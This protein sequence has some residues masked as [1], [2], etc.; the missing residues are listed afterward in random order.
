[1]TNDNVEIHGWKA[2]VRDSDNSILGIVTDKYKV[3]QNTEA[4]E[5]TDNL[6]GNGVRYETAGSLASGKRI[7]LLAK[8]E[9]STI[10][11]EDI[12]PYLVFTNSHDGSN[13]I[14]VA[15]TPVRV[16]CQ[17]TLNFA[18]QNASRTWSAIHTGNIATKL[19]EAKETLFNAKEY[20][21]ELD[22]EFGILKNAKIDDNKLRELV[23][24]LVPITDKDSDKQ[25][26]KINTMKNEIIYRYYNAPDLKDREE[27]LFRF[28][29]AVSDFATHT[30]PQRKTYDW[31]NNMFMRTIDG[32]ALI[33]RSYRMASAIAA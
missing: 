5:F 18:L 15:M 16:V 14:K 4:F 11:G 30:Q 10:T 27:S 6:L 29:N 20:M 12:D 19:E 28:V 17:N 31:Q 26:D 13:A 2:N 1:M 23:N 25:K 8:M 32:N 7:W 33:D 9:T 24:D 3:V 21:T 22:K